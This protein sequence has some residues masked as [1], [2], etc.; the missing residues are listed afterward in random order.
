MQRMLTCARNAVFSIALSV[1]L[2]THAGSAA[3]SEWPVADMN[4]AIEQTNFVVNR[5]C[6]GTL[7]SVTERLI[8]T[9]FHCVERDLEVRQREVPQPDGTVKTVKQ[10]RFADIKVEQHSYDGFARTGTATFVA[11]VVADDKARDLA[12]VRVSGPIP[13][14]YASPIGDIP[15]RGE[16]VYVVGNPAGLENTV[17]EGVVSNVNRTFEFPWTEEKLA[18]IQFSGGIYGGNSGGALYNARGELVGVPAAG[19]ASANFIGL[20]IPADVV[21]FFLRERCFAK[22]FDA[23]ADDNACRAKRFPTKPQAH[24]GNTGDNM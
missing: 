19:L 12:L 23:S 20:A 2:L 6:S 15:M 17:V 16:R 14:N 21:K 22:V 11:Q 18:M 7:I 24:A 8:L 5:G 3:A 9:N 4:R 1:A 13:N 10:R